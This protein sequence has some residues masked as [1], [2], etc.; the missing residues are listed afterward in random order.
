MYQK[1]YTLMKTSTTHVISTIGHG[2]RKYDI[3]FTKIVQYINLY[4]KQSFKDS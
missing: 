1:I 4:P 3:S 2:S